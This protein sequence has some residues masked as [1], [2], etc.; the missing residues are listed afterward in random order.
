[1]SRFMLGGEDKAR[2]GNGGAGE[3]RR[4]LSYSGP[5]SR[6]VGRVRQMA[7]IRSDDGL[8]SSYLRFGGGHDTDGKQGR[9]T[10]DRL[11]CLALVQKELLSIL[12]EPHAMCAAT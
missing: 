2:D 11:I 7:G 10:S 5:S 6:R 4:S 8:C 9:G 1:M 3:V 12:L